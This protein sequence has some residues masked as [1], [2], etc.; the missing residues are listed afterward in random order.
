M[1]ATRIAASLRVS[2]TAGLPRAGKSPVA[3][4]LAWCA[5]MLRLRKAWKRGAHPRVSAREAYPRRVE[6]NTLTKG[7]IDKE[8]R[9]VRQD[10]FS[11]SCLTAASRMIKS[12]RWHSLGR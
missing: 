7:G 9:L 6:H 3:V 2:L 8:P 11:D 4:A 5:S 1:S 10:Q 12:R